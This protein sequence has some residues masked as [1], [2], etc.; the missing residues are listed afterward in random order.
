MRKIEVI[1][2]FLLLG[3]NHRQPV[4]HTSKILVYIYTTDECINKFAIS[5]M[6]KPTP[7]VNKVLR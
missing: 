5:Y 6:I 2:L 7:H 1:P 3:L 4:L